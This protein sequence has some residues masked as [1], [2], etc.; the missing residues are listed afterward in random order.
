MVDRF[1]HPSLLLSQL[2]GI[3]TCNRETYE[4][5]KTKPAAKP[6]ERGLDLEN[7]ISNPVE[8]ETFFLTSL[9]IELIEQ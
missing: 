4:K 5:P 2:D 6:I 1:N 8:A 3:A 7:H 9:F